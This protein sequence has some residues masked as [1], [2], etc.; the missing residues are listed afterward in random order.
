MIELF[1]AIIAHFSKFGGKFTKTNSLKMFFA[2][3][4]RLNKTLKQYPPLG[5]YDSTQ[6][7]IDS[8]LI[9]L[10]WCFVFQKHW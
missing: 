9:L 1:F 2:K 10:K 4:F 8:S 7:S 5:L 6:D 3:I